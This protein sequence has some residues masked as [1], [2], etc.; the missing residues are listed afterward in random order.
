CCQPSDPHSP[1][2]LLPRI[3]IAVSNSGVEIPASEQERIFDKFYRIPKHDPWKYGGTGLGLA[4]VKK[5]TERLG[6]QITV[7]SA[8]GWTTFILELALHPSSPSC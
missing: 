7:R 6:G 2:T 8:N 1:S 3:Q 4:L 5:L